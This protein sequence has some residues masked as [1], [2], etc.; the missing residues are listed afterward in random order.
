MPE[1]KL[2]D[3]KSAAQRLAGIATRTP[4][5]ENLDV[6]KQLGCRLLIKAECAQRT[7]AFK[8]RGAYNRICQMTPEEKKNGV[9][10]YSSGNHAKGVAMAARLLGTSALIVMPQDAPAA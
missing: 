4:L 6:N 1:P 9:L 8:F 7:G 2:D 10:T 5:L 3:F